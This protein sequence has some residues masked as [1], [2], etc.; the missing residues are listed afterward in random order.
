MS[1]VLVTSL[2]IPQEFYLFL[3]TFGN[4]EAKIAW[5]KEVSSASLFLLPK[6]KVNKIS[7]STGD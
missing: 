6:M 5:S 2:L 3:Y 1:V 4:R 7:D